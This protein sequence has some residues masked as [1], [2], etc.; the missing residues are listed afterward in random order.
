MEDVTSLL[1]WTQDVASFLGEP[2]SFC[3]LDHGHGQK[4]ESKGRRLPTTVGCMVSLGE[5]CITWF[6]CKRSQ[7]CSPASSV[8]GSQV[9][10]SWKDFLCLGGGG[11]AVSHS[12]PNVELDS[13]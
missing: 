3:D 2:S 10:G 11:D 8:K 9:D 5:T 1:I 7:F 12:R 4:T 6:A 13:V